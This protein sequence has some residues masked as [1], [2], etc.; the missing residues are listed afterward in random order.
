MLKH[1]QELVVMLGE[2]NRLS[3]QTG[4]E[5]HFYCFIISLSV[6]VN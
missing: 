1:Q 4:S 2:M 6:E 3:T 5:T